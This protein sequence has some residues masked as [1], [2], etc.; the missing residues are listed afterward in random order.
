MDLNTELSSQLCEWKQEG[1]TLWGGGFLEHGIIL[2]YVQGVCGDVCVTQ[3]KA[4]PE[5]QEIIPAGWLVA[6]G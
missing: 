6:A 3:S 5:T 2:H 4:I 1:T